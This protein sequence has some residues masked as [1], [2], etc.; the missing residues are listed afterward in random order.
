[1]EH[2][3]ACDNSSIRIIKE[4]EFVIN[5]NGHIIEGAVNSRPFVFNS[6]DVVTINNLKCES[7]KLKGTG[8]YPV[9][10][11][12]TPKGWTGPKEFDEKK[13]EGSFRAHQVPI[14]ITRDN[15]ENLGLIE[16]WL[17]SYRVDNLFDEKGKLIKF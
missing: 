7:V 6:K 3:Y 12:T 10:I 9:I 5:G 14:P 17:K 1:M 15:P 16:K 2:D 11:L 4:N 8:N 13:I